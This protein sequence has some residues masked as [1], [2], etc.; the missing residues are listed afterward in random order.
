[1]KINTLTLYYMFVFLLSCS[2]LSFC[3]GETQTKSSSFKKANE[4]PSSS[5]VSFFNQ[6]RWKNPGFV[7]CPLLEMHDEANIFISKTPLPNF[8]NVELNGNTELFYSGDTHIPY[9]LKGNDTILIKDN[10]S[11]N[12]YSLFSSKEERNNEINFFQAAYSNKIPLLYVENSNQQKGLIEIKDVTNNLI[13]ITDIYNRAKKF[14]DNYFLNHAVSND[15][16]RFTEEYV[17]FD[18]YIKIF[19]YLNSRKSID[20][21]IANKYFDLSSDSSNIYHNCNYALQ[22]ALYQYT[23][24][25]LGLNTNKIDFE[26]IFPK[27]ENI[28][29]KQNASLVKF[30]LL[31]NFASSN[32]ILKNGKLTALNKSLENPDFQNVISEYM[33][34]ME[35]SNNFKNKI[36]DRQGSVFTLE[37]I[38][39]RNKGKVILVDFWASWCAPCRQEFEFYPKL[40]TLLDTSKV[41]F[42]FISIDN[43]KASW[44]KTVNSEKV[45]TT[46]ENFLLINTSKEIL[47]KMKL[48][49]IP[50]YYLYNEKGILINIDAP[51]PSDER[52]VTEINQVLHKK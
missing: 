6:S 46:S 47:E 4:S 28:Y 38:I 37:N 40:R 45:L 48:L 16:R 11:E 13:A 31:K 22:G 33:K 5:F 32:E 44:L 34:D 35:F 27:L 23:K 15:F 3:Q 52:L 1:M 42:I 51:Y 49:S 17:R 26:K 20:S 9:I 30:I 24:F 50:R 12:I 36:I 7:R 8:K 10:I 25:T 19:T 18:H 29:S 43:S 41:K 2:L 14:R 39:S 21:L